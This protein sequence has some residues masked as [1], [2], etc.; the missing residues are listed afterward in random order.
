MNEPPPY[1]MVSEPG[2]SAWWT[3]VLALATFAVALVLTPLV[4]A[5]ALRAGFF[6]HPGTR[7]VHLVAM[8]TGGGER[9]VPSVR[10]ALERFC[11][12]R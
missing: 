4:R 12:D 10:L 9:T 6:D 1:Q 8:P 11:D 3:L 7:K 5:W 2:T